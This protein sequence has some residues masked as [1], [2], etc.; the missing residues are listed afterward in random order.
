MQLIYSNFV[1]HYH[2]SFLYFHCDRVRHTQTESEEAL[3]QG[4]KERLTQKT[5]KNAL[6][7]KFKSFQ[8]Q[9]KKYL[10]FPFENKK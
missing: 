8:I 9:L 6:C 10:Y 1:D 5:E 2:K 4:K 7:K 3:G